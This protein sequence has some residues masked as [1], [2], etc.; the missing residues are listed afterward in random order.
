MLEI[1]LT[2][3]PILVKTGVLCI[4][5]LNDIPDT[6][7]CFYQDSN[8]HIDWKY[9]PGGVTGSLSECDHTYPNYVQ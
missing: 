3:P 6:T 1:L 9:T 7:I 4:V 2:E 5:C 8:Y